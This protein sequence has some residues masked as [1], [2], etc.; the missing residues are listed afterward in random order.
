MSVQRSN[1][2]TVIIVPLAHRHPITSEASLCEG[3]AGACAADV[4]SKLLAG[5]QLSTE[6]DFVPEVQLTS[7]NI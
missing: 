4:T 5:G 6:D 2:P 1:A 7:S 3:S